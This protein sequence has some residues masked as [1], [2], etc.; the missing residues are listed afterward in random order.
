MDYEA[1]YLRLRDYLET[2]KCIK[3][4]DRIQELEECLREAIILMEDVRTGDYKPDTLTTQ[5]W[6]QKRSARGDTR[7]P[8]ISMITPTGT[9]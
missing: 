6:K 4:V 8:L 2:G 5:P 1:E 7:E 9:G 3:C